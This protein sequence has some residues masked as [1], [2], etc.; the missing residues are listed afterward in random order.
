MADNEI[1]TAVMMREHARGVLQEW[2][3]GYTDVLGDGKQRQVVVE[4]VDDNWI[5]VRVRRQNAHGGYD[6][7][8]K[9]YKIAVEV[10]EVT[11]EQ[12]VPAKA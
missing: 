7:R 2:L 11:D 8:E 9:R 6:R 4:S 10:K 5:H 12:P 3:Q 1:F